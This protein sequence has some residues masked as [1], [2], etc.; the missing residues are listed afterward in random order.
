[1]G[2]DNTDNLVVVVDNITLSTAMHRRLAEYVRKA[3]ITAD[4][5]YYV[6]EQPMVEIRKFLRHGERMFCSR[7]RSELMS[8][9]SEYKFALIPE[10]LTEVVELA[11]KAGIEY[12]TVRL[13]GYPVK[14]FCSPGS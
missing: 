6:G 9:L 11:N 12:E 7:N 3:G 10:H 1:M 8:L 14:N 13:A 4:Y 2:V 5:I